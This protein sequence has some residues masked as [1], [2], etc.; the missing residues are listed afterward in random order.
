MGLL[1]AAVNLGVWRWMQAARGDS[2]AILLTLGSAAISVVFL[3]LLYRS[4]RMGAE[5]QFFGRYRE[6]AGAGQW[7]V[8][9][10]LGQ[11]LIDDGLEGAAGDES[12]MI[13]Q[14]DHRWEAVQQEMQE[15]IT[16]QSEEVRRDLEVAKEFQQ[17]YL[18]R[19]YPKIPAV[20][21]KG[22]LRLEFCHRYEPAL[23]LGGDFFDILTLA[24][25][26]AGV[27]VADVMGHG[28][29]SALIT[30]MIRTIIADLASQG[31]NA[32]HFISELNNQVCGFFNILPHPLFASAFYFVV[33][34]TARH[35]TFTTAGHPAPF[36]LRRSVGRVTR[37]ELDPPAGAALG[38]LPGEDY[39]GG[40]CRLIPG[41]IF[42]FFTDG[43]YEARNELGD[44]FGISR[45][46]SVIEST[47][48][49]PAPVIVDAIR[50]AVTAFVGNEPIADD[51]C[52]VAV[53]VTT[54][55]A[56][57]GK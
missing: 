11:T 9:R 21:V 48:Y 25:D 27:F 3:L 50:D 29:R 39:G 38:L 23:A 20:H 31:R 24:P 18:N 40:S 53:E 32:P 44:E 28:T 34:T 13:Q 6:L 16:P 10:V 14:L 5:D 22:R 56:P 55:E 49:K 43:V 19:P 41:D 57:E 4:A 35:A 7:A 30:A 8:R 47:L 1:L 33:D 2:S 42:I 54:D 12:E 45:M 52:M 15:L 37:V 26:C 51:I 17:A 46:A 36:H